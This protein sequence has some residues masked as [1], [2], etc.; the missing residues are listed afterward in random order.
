MQIYCA[1]VILLE[2]VLTWQLDR[3]FTKGKVPASALI[4]AIV[5]FFTYLPIQGR[6][7]GWW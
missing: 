3:E 5:T 1:L 6:V 2:V 7:M 4:G